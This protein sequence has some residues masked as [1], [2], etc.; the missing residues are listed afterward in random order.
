[1]MNQAKLTYSPLGRTLE[2]QTLLKAKEENKLI[3]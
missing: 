2:K 1:M 3:L